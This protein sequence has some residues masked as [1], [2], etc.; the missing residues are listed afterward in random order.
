MFLYNFS[1]VQLF[2]LLVLLNKTVTEVPCKL[3]E[4]RSSGK[5]QTHFHI[6]LYAIFQLL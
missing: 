1:T 4:S 3:K 2:V 6:Y 5:G